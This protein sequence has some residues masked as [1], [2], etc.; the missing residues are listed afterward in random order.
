MRSAWCLTLLG[1]SLYRRVLP[2]ATTNLYCGIAASGGVSTP[3]SRTK[4]ATV[5]NERAVARPLLLRVEVLGTVQLALLVG[6]L[7]DNERAVLLALLDLAQL[8]LALLL[9]ADGRGR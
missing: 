1:T 2:T 6:E 7:A 3:G 8:L 5:L 4:S 9:R